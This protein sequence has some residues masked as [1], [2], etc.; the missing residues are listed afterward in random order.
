MKKLIVII[1]FLSLILPAAALADDTFRIAEHYTVLIDNCVMDA[2]GPKGDK[3]FTDFD[4]K[5]IDLYLASDGVSGYY[6]ET[7]CLYG[8]FINS[9]M[10]KVKKID[11]NGQQLLVDDAGNSIS[12]KTDEDGTVWISIGLL[13]VRMQ[14]IDNFS[15]YYDVQ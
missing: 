10:C 12:M 7:T 1:L 2:R 4:S 14:K 6:I 5:T 15:A 11:L 3:I 13:Y 8:T 9:G